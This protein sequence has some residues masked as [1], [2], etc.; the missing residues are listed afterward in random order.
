LSLT[1]HHACDVMGQ[2]AVHGQASFGS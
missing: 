2:D 1:L